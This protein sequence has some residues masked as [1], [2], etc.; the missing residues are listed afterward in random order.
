MRERGDRN[1]HATGGLAKSSTFRNPLS[2]FPRPRPLSGWSRLRGASLSTEGSG[3]FQSRRPRRVALE[4]AGKP[5]RHP[6]SLCPRA[7]GGLARSHPPSNYGSGASQNK[8]RLP[9]CLWKGDLNLPLTSH[10]AAVSQLGCQGLQ[11]L[12][13]SCLGRQRG[14]TLNWGLGQSSGPL[15]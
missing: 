15:P 9:G 8:R 10:S 7:D 3:Q 14:R 2:P 1:G 5:S 13:L 6:C 11:T 4:R 12:A